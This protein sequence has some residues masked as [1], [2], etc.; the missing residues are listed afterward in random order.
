MQLEEIREYRLGSS[1]SMA[2]KEATSSM[3][4]SACHVQGVWVELVL[5]VA[6]KGHRGDVVGQGVQG[7][8]GGVESR[9]AVLPWSQAGLVT[10]VVG[11]L[12]DCPPLV[13]GHDDRLGTVVIVQD[14]R[15]LVGELLVPHEVLIE[16]PVQAQLIQI[17]I[18]TRTEIC[19]ML[20][21]KPTC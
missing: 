12:V 11:K 2:P 17:C 1:S 16:V 7:T 6:A 9:H 18:C 5:G 13:P 10:L 19:Y 20:H 21:R 3:G 15:V 8:H 4:R 14:R